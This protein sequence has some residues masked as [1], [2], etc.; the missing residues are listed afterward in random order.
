M[1]PQERIPIG[2]PPAQPP[3]YFG[4]P[5][6]TGVT[7]RH[8]GVP[9]QEPWISLSDVPPA[10]PIQQFLIGSIEYLGDIHIG[11]W[12]SGSLGVPIRATHRADVLTLVA[13]V[14][15]PAKRLAELSGDRTRRLHQPCQTASCVDD[16]TFEDGTGWTSVD[17]L[18]TR[19]ASI[20]YW[21]RRRQRRIG[22]HRPQDEPTPTPWQQHVGVS[23]PPTDPGPDGGC[24]INQGIV[25]GHDHRPPPLGPEPD[26]HRFQRPTEIRVV[27]VT[28]IG[29]DPHTARSNL[30]QSG[31][32]SPLGPHY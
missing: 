16:P 10:E 13:P 8:Q 26:G 20:I 3:F 4:V 15:P 19:P 18:P 23:P 31:C 30:G 11:A 29:G 9:T 5:G 21:D 17:A 22:N 2:E 14:E 25:V 12:V 1:N 32:R 27:I 24:P 6:L 28:G 7:E